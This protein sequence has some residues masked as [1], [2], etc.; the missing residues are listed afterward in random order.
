MAGDEMLPQRVR[1]DLKILVRKKLISKAGRGAAARYTLLGMIG[2]VV[3]VRL[4]T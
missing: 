2:T 4:C 3:L 1:L